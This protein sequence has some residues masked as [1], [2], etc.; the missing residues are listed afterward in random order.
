MQDEYIGADNNFFMHGL[1]R[2][3]TQVRNGLSD[4]TYR[5]GPKDKEREKI[6]TCHSANL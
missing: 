3:V 5:G 4:M 2:C 6:R 1:L